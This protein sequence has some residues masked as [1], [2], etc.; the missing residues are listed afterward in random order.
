MIGKVPLKPL[1]VVG[2]EWLATLLQALPA[3]NVLIVV[4]DDHDPGT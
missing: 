2:C 3:Q 1:K 4:A